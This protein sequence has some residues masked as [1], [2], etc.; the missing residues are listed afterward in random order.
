MFLKSIRQTLNP[1]QKKSFQN[2]FRKIKPAINQETKRAE[3]NTVVFLEG[4]SQKKNLAYYDKEI[5]ETLKLRKNIQ[6][7]IKL[8][9]RQDIGL[10]ASTYFRYQAMAFVVTIVVC[11]INLFQIIHKGRDATPKALAVTDLLDIEEQYKEDEHKKRS[12]SL[13]DA[14]VDKVE[15]NR[16][17]SFVDASDP[18]AYSKVPDMDDIT[19]D[20]RSV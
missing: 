19:A 14:L 18:D 20:V 5:Y 13:W 7:E 17:S 1:Q 4:F 8:V 11:L 10:V 3:R 12:E 6:V 15:R 2:H 16:F 9:D